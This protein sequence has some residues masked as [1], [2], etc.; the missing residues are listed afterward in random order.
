MTYEIICKYYQN[1]LSAQYDV[2]E[3]FEHAL[4]R[5]EIREEF[6]RELITKRNS[7]IKA[8]TGVLSNGTDSSGQC[9]ILI[10]PNTATVEPFGSKVMMKVENC[11]IV[12]EVKS[13]ATGLDFKKAND[14]AEVIKNLNPVQH[15][16]YGMF[17]YQTKLQKN[18]IFKRFGYK[19]DNDYEAF[20]ED[21]S[22]ELI[23]PNIDFVISIKDDPD[24]GFEQFFIIRNEINQRFNLVNDFPVIKNFFS[25]I[26]NSCSM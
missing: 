26:E 16:I 19:F 21:E 24:G 7:S 8:Y 20:F 6:I 23:Y 11:K 2:S 13:N 22:L 4:T 17:C 5:G 3:I 10:A 9:D 18:T 12:C 1:L 25:L 15:P 14:S